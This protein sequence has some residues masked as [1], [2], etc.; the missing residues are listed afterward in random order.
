MQNSKDLFIDVI[1]LTHLPRRARQIYTYRAPSNLEFKKGQLVKIPLKTRVIKGAVYQLHKTSS[2]PRLKKINAFL[3][4]EIFITDKQFELAHLISEHYGAPLT[5][6]IKSFLPQKLQLSKRLSAEPIKRK[7]SGRVAKH[8][9]HLILTGKNADEQIAYLLKDI[10]HTLKT[11][12]QV[13]LLSPTLYELEYWQD[14]VKK[15]ILSHQ[16]VVHHS[17]LKN[18]IYRDNFFY[19]KQ[20]QP[21]LVFA[22]RQGPFLPFNNLGLIIMTDSNHAGYKQWDQKPNYHTREVVEFL[23]D[24][25]HSRI[26]YTSAW[27]SI[28]EWHSV[29][30]KKIKLVT[31]V[32]WQRLKN[33]KI[34]DLSHETRGYYTPLAD[35][36]EYG[37]KRIA[38][39]KDRW[40][41]VLNRLGHF[42]L[43]FCHDCSWQALCPECKVWLI[44]YN[45]KLVC[46][47]CRH[48]ELVP[49]FC[50]YC[51]GA[52]IKK[53]GMGIQKLSTHISKLNQNAKVILYNKENNILN[54]KTPP[55]SGI[56]VAT[57]AIFSHPDLPLFSKIVIVNAD[58]EI[59][60][61]DW[62]S[63][64]RFAQKL[65]R[66]LLRI[67]KNGCVYLQT[68]HPDNFQS[69]LTSRGFHDIIKRELGVRKRYEYPPYSELILLKS[70]SQKKVPVESFSYPFARNI[71]RI[72]KNIINVY[73]EPERTS[74]GWQYSILVKA[75]PTDKTFKKKLYSLAPTNWQIDVNPL[76][77]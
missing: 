30:T 23:R 60:Y 52:F 43:L 12:R 21:L 3:S 48:Q 57:D 41:F 7:Q 69:F 68:Y 2:I 32:I 37:I 51:K 53:Y 56:V 65:W 77:L 19:I 63:V 44:N 76:H 54:I 55:S 1:P 64:D 26:V 49:P 11:G 33:I 10:K 27:P 38:A 66:S 24:I 47:R 46:H 73:P 17:K 29:Q 61:P 71:E 35:D 18:S 31:P 58:S 42:R 15:E 36:I 67:E 40:L 50:P 45:D 62:R 14:K 75:K 22:L 4:S 72:T 70:V 13:L 25:H 39:E 59:N 74:K 34:I 5:L 9:S 8:P 20:K 28:S 16:Q 6:V